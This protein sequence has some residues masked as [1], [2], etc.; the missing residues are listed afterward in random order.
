MNTSVN[1]PLSRPDISLYTNPD[2]KPL[3]LSLSRLS[4]TIGGNGGGGQRP[5]SFG[6]PES[7]S[8][9]AQNPMRLNTESLNA[10]KTAGTAQGGDNDL[11]KMLEKIVQLLQEIFQSL[12]QK[13]GQGEEGEGGPAPVGKSSGGAPAQAQA[14]SGGAGGG[15][16]A[17]AA[18]GP[19]G[20]PPPTQNAAVGDSA[21][22]QSVAGNAD[23]SGLHL[24]PALADHEKAI[25]KAA[26]ASG[27]PANVIAGMMWAESRGDSSASTVNG[28]N[29]QS[30][31]GLMQVN[32]AT[33]AEVQSK[34]SEKF[35]DSMTADEKNIMTGAL[36][37][38]D[39]HEAFGGNM[40]A[41]LRAYNSGANTVNRDDPSDI[42]KTGLGDP[43][44]VA[45]V[46]NFAEI[47]GSGKGQLPA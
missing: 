1:A 15:A 12:M 39:Q 32:S 18:G 16:G 30:D 26:D 8:G 17:P 9:A 34:H 38:K 7:T 28:G 22:T 37:L 29:G 11:S 21:P 14:P 23:T 25:G 45:N 20:G 19:T 46:N 33:A 40:D 3:D 4:E 24:P 35:N 5:I 41:A 10:D 43:N 44:Y 13:S 31:S 27:M 42:S 6:G 47:I 36:Y 2:S